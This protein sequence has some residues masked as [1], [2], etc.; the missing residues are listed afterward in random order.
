MDD[1]GKYFF[2][3]IV[4]LVVGLL[5]QRLK[6]QVKLRYWMPHSFL[7]EL[8]EENVVLQTDSLSIQNLGR[9]PAKDVE[10]IYKARPDF[11]KFAPPVHFEEAKTPTGEHI[12]KIPSLGPKEHVFLQLLSYKTTP[13]ILS[14]RSEQG[15]GKLM[16]I[17]I[18][19]WIPYWGQVLTGSLIIIGA[20]FILYWLVRALWFLSVSIGIL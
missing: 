17:Q 10:I 18:Q 7:F 5:L 20:A 2:T 14:V 15:L 16:Q 6:P 13:Q 3:G 9:E 8:R 19:P 11:F 12:I 1:L 4:S